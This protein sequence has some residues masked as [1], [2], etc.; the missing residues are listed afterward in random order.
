MRVL[1][2]RYLSYSSTATEVLVRLKPTL[3]VKSDDADQ[4]K[5]F[6]AHLICPNEW[7]NVRTGQ[8]SVFSWNGV[9]YDLL[10]SACTIYDVT[11]QLI[12][13]GI[14]CRYSHSDNKV[15]FDAQG[16]L[17][18]SMAN[19][20]ADL[21][22][23]ERRVHQLLPG[24]C[25]SKQVDMNQTSCVNFHTNLSRT[26]YVYDGTDFVL[27]DVLCTLPVDVPSFANLIYRDP[28]GERGCLHTLELINTLHMYWTDQDYL[29]LP[30]DAFK[31]P[32]FLLLGVFE[33]KYDAL[34]QMAML[35]KLHDLSA[36]QLDVSQTSLLAAHG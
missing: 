1:R 30:A 28:A 25:S 16:S 10:E 15:Y 21:L 29:P 31:R 27:S 8:N 9:R 19:S 22:G 12:S 26:V 14:E 6:V 13:A 20:I 5:V 33:L 36:Q 3:L 18:V 7:L 4:I 2:T 34:D 24:Y 17:D 32:W 35:G 11:Y 23:L